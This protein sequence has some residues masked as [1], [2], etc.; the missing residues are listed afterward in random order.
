[1]LRG[2]EIK[3]ELRDRDDGKTLHKRTKVNYKTDDSL[4]IRSVD[5]FIGIES[6]GH[7]RERNRGDLHVKKPLTHRSKSREETLS[8]GVPR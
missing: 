2:R 7:P 5:L 4:D 8:I 3:Q 6:W 1:M